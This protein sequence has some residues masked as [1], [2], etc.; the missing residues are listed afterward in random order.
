[1]LSSDTAL[2]RKG[3]VDGSSLL[4]GNGEPAATTLYNQKN[5]MP[6]KNGQKSQWTDENAAPP[7]FPLPAPNTFGQTHPQQ[8][9]SSYP[10]QCGQP[11]PT[12]NTFG[13][14]QQSTYPNNFNFPQQHEQTGFAPPMQYNQSSQQYGQSQ[15]FGQYPAPPV[16]NEPKKSSF[17]RLP[18]YGKKK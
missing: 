14:P 16:Q 18:G 15:Q 17:F 6:P 4:D 5:Q 9:I 1:M 3:R 11:A 10:T 8:H 2:D 13:F 12:Q 7:N